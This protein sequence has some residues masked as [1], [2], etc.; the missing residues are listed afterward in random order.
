VIF[1]ADI[2]HR[3]SRWRQDTSGYLECRNIESSYRIR[4]L[5]IFIADII[6]T[7]SRWRLDTSGYFKCR[8]IESSWSLTIHI[9]YLRHHD[10]HLHWGFHVCATTHNENLVD[11]PTWALDRPLARILG[12]VMSKL[13]PNS[14]L[15]F[16]MKAV[17]LHTFQILCIQ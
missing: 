6:H 9:R 8:N 16:K 13:L 10:I 3:E 1:I 7:E 2:I 12:K 14:F 5:V 4:D 11:L 15:S 17:T